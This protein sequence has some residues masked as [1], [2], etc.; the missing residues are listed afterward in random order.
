[1]QEVLQR[2]QRGVSGS[3]VTGVVRLSWSQC[4]SLRKKRFVHHSIR[5]RSPGKIKTFKLSYCCVHSYLENLQY[6]MLPFILMSKETYLRVF[7][8]FIINTKEILIV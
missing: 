3:G 7:F 1:M 5:K 8:I 6:M 4:Y 2:E